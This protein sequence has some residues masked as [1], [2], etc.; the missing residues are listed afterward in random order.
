MG[1]Y[2][3]G[4]RNSNGEHL[5]S[6]QVDKKLLA[7]NTSFQ[8]PVRHI[9]TRTGYIIK[10]YTAPRNSHLTIPYYSKIDYIICRHRYK[11]LLVNS[12]NYGGIHIKSVHKIVVA[13]LN[14]VYPKHKPR[15]HFDVTTL[16][17]DTQAKNN[18]N[19]TLH[20]I[21][22]DCPVNPN[23]EEEL[24]NLFKSVQDVAEKSLGYLPT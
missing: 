17:S 2:A 16:I 8:Y 6:F 14:F 5:L 10:D 11:K 9:T 23:P 13:Q 3:S 22:C 7:C 15:K 12:R 20:D 21:L 4:K 19:D 1:M 18:Y 24:N